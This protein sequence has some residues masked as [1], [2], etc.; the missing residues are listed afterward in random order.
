M[1]GKGGNVLSSDAIKSFLESGIYTVE[2]RDSV[3]STNAQ[4]KQAA[5]N[6][7][8]EFTVLAANNQHMRRRCLCKSR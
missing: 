5:E 3:S 4:L 2:V 1:L 8:P 7:A 6:G